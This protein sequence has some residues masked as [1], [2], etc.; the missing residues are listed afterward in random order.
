[1][2]SRGLTLATA[3]ELHGTYSE[4]ELS[5]I[6]DIEDMIIAAMEREG[7][8]L[9]KE[10]LKH[11]KMECGLLCHEKGIKRED[12]FDIAYSNLKKV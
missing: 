3:G 11:L 9:S 4:D 8:I 10:T 12:I 2:R 7:N 6:S 5:L 1:M